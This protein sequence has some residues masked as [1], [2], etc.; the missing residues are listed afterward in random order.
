[1]HIQRDGRSTIFMIFTNL[2]GKIGIFH[3]NLR[4]I[5]QCHEMPPK[6]M[7]A[8]LKDFPFHGGFCIFTASLPR[9]KWCLLGKLRSGDFLFRGELLMVQKIPRSTCLDG[10]KTLVNFHGISTTNL[11]QLVSW[12]PD[13]KQPPWLVCFQTVRVAK[14]SPCFKPHPFVTKI[15]GALGFSGGF[16]GAEVGATAPGE[17][18]A[19]KAFVPVD[20][21]NVLL[22]SPCFGGGF[23]KTRWWFQIFFHPYLEKWSNLTKI[24]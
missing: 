13:F 3:S 2:P 6:S 10:G 22:F 15:W 14:F 16:D 17:M 18:A 12:D 4:S 7:A 19:A 1:M 24:F 11:P 23:F 8:F 9:E 20:R 21:W 5:F